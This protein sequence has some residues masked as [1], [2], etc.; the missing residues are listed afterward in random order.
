MATIDSDEH[1]N[2]NLCLFKFWFLWL[3]NIIICYTS[4]KYVCVYV[5]LCVCGDLW[6]ART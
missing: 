5:Y 6:P 4:A 1:S 3:M 2:Y